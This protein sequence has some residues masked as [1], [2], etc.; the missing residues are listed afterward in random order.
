M[1]KFRPGISTQHSKYTMR[2]KESS[3]LFPLDEIPQDI[4]LNEVLKEVGSGLWCFSHS[5]FWIPLVHQT[6]HFY[7]PFFLMDPWIIGLF[8]A[9]WSRLA[10]AF[11]LGHRVLS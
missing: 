11:F 3:F 7:L 1:K 5:N 2:N 9:E 8:V 10:V 6:E 4:R